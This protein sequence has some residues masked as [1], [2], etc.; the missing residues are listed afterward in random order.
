MSE[1]KKT[2]ELIEETTA[3]STEHDTDEYEKV[4]CICHRPESKTGKMIELRPNIVYLSGLYA[5]VLRQHE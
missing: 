5:E 3:S 2:E 1:E 4:C